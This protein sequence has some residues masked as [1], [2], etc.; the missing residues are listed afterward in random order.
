VCC[1]I[2][3]SLLYTQALSLISLASVTLG[4]V[5]FRS[6]LPAREHTCLGIVK[7]HLYCIC[8][9]YCEVK[10]VNVM[11]NEAVKR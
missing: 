10:V 2:F 4:G 5:Y 9:I 3:A 8:T 11:L 1:C 7:L 6:S